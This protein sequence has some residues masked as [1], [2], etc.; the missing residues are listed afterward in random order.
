[1]GLGEE[2]SSERRGV[3]AKVRK[4][5]RQYTL[6]LAD[7]RAVEKDTKTA[8]WLSAYRYWLGRWAL[9]GVNT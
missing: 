4:R 1:M 8:E 3:V 5:G 7:L 2:Q 6:A 9:S